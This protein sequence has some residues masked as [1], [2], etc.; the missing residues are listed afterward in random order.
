[1]A[2]TR[3]KGTTVEERVKQIIADNLSVE[4][5]EVTPQSSLRDDLGADSLD[6][7]EIVMCFE[8]EFGISISDEDGDKMKTV[9]DAVKI[10]EGAVKR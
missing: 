9:A 10:V 2:N 8:T 6:L 7:V 5:E 4:L 1:M 3:I